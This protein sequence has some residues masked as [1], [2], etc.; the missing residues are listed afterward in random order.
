[1][2]T[3]PIATGK[4]ESL[5]INGAQRQEICFWEGGPRGDTHAAG[6]TR[7]LSGH[8]GEYIR[9][10]SLS[11]SEGLQLAKLDRALH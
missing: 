1:M 5:C 2:V 11:G 6:S 10:S 7:T 9:T 3:Q 4:V 8:D